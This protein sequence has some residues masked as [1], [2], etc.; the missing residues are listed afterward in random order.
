M[1]IV[2]G[3]MDILGS[4]KYRTIFHNVS[5]ELYISMQVK[6]RQTFSRSSSHRALSTTMV[7]AA[8]K[9]KQECFHRIS[10]LG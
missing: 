8:N 1:I 6:T 7:I 3:Q 9:K 10:G 5:F 2:E 4:L